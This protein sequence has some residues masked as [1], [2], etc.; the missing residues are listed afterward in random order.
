MAGPRH[1]KQDGE[2]GWR[3]D[4]GRRAQCW[5]IEAS[6][7]SRRRACRRQVELESA[8]VVWFPRIARGRTPSPNLEGGLKALCPLTRREIERRFGLGGALIMRCRRGRF[9]QRHHR[10]GREIGGHHHVTGGGEL[11]VVL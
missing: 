5:C 9:P 2:P 6:R 4:R 10:L 7:A 1:A 3:T 8:P 11:V